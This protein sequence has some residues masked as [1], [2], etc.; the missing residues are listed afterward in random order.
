MIICFDL[1]GTLINTEEWI[2]DAQIK[3]LKKYGITQTKKQIYNFWGLTLSDQIKKLKPKATQEEIKNINKE[4]NKIRFSNSSKLKP[5]PN[6]KRTLKSLSKKYSLCLLSNNSHKSIIKA[7]NATKIDKKLF[8]A[9]VGA[10]EVKH[11]KPFPDEIYK[12]EKKLKKK[13]K[14]MVGDTVQDIKTAKAA[15]VKSIIIKTG[16]KQIWKTLNKADFIIEDI[17]DIHSIIKKE[18]NK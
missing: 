4:F 3:A 15:K 10:D 8:A 1:D 6:T 11:P 14:F 2:V 7:L 12:T 18:G 9:I 17:K 13:V 5:Y 16:P